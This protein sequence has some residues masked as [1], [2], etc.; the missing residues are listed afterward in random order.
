MDEEINKLVEQYGEKHT[1]KLG[2]TNTSIN[3]SCHEINA[4]GNVNPY[5]WQITELYL[6]H[7]KISNL[8]GIQQFSR[9][10]TLSLKFNLISNPKE[11]LKIPNK[12]GL[13][14]LNLKG[15]PIEMLPY[16][17][18]SQLFPK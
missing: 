18:I 15:N 10:A 7:N 2:I 11:L 12:L 4:I 1:V 13:R 9:L 3:L 5:Y 16:V 6:D 8:D 14:K 17:K